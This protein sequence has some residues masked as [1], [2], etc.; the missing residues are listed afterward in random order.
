MVKNKAGEWNCIGEYIEF[1]FEVR[2]IVV[3]QE[4][5][6]LNQTF[7]CTQNEGTKH[8][9]KETDVFLSL[10][11]VLLQHSDLVEIA[12]SFVLS[13]TVQP[14]LEVGILLHSTQHS[15]F[16]TLVLL[17][18]LIILIFFRRDANQQLFV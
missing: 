16:F 6:P 17:P 2:V 5:E 8:Y 9:P 14:S 4:Q 1:D 7:N 3:Q 18:V 15:V 11:D 13:H 10:F 12:Q